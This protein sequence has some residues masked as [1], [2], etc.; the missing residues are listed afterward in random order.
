MRNLRKFLKI[1][2]F[3]KLLAIGL[4]GIFF[5]F[6]NGK[7]LAAPGVDTIYAQA[8]PADYIALDHSIN[9]MEKTKSIKIA[10]LAVL[11]ALNLHY[12]PGE[13]KAA[14]QELNPGLKG[15]LVSI[16]SGSL[17]TIVAPLFFGSLINLISLEYLNTFYYYL[18]EGAKNKEQLKVRET[19]N[20]EYAAAVA[21]MQSDLFQFEGIYENSLDELEAN[22]PA[23]GDSISKLADM[24]QKAENSD[25]VNYLNLAASRMEAMLALTNYGLEAKLNQYKADKEGVSL[26]EVS[27]YKSTASI[28]SISSKSP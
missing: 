18:K 25:T 3:K 27:N 15:K 16:M 14:L 12:S 1:Y 8:I 26:Q 17:S 7:V 23:W 28:S 19:Q 22:L 20:L 11:E 4:P 2:W 10:T 21:K 24:A 5:I 6:I 13:K 9:A